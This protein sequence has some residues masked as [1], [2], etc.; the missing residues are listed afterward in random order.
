MA[1]QKQEVATIKDT[2][3]GQWQNG[4][5][6][7][8]IIFGPWQ[9]DTKGGMICGQWQ[10]GVVAAASNQTCSTLSLDR[11]HNWAGIAAIGSFPATIA[12]NSEIRFTHLRD[13]DFGSN[14]AVQY[15]GLNDNGVRCAWILAWHAPVE[16]D[17]P[18][19][20]NRVYVDCGRKTSIDAMTWDQIRKKLDTSLTEDNA[21]D[22]ATKTSANAS[23]H[24][25][26]RNCATLVA[27]FRT[28]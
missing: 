1:T 10:N 16:N 21:T 2:I 23:I 11:F 25:R 15:S 8:G 4:T 19:P 24:D 18:C 3:M 12:P 20:P 5:K 27:N 28:M 14:G 26:T 13:G 17:P 7:H 9:N 22:K 6:D